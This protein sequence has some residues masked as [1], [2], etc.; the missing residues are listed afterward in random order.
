[1]YWRFF[2]PSMLYYYTTLFTLQTLTNDEK[3]SKK[4]RQQQ[5][6]NAH[7]SPTQYNADFFQILNLALDTL[8]FNFIRLLRCIHSL[9]LNNISTINNDLYYYNSSTT[10]VKVVYANYTIILLHNF[11][12]ILHITIWIIQYK[13]YK[14]ALRIF[15]FYILKPSLCP[16]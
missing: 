2:P 11:E 14:A 8:D 1:M 3:L 16:K 9:Y 12:Y 13:Q 7:R 4:F 15:Q 6:A 5:C 10:Y